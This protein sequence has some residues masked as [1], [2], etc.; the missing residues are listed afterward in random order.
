MNN[1]D[2]ASHLSDRILEDWSQRRADEGPI[3]GLI[4]LYEMIADARNL[5]VEDI[6]HD[7]RT[8]LASRAL[9][10][11]WPGFEQVAPLYTDGRVEVVVHNEE[12]PEIFAQLESDLRNQF[13]R[14]DIRIEHIGSTAVPGL[15]EKPIIDVMICVE[16][17]AAEERYVPQISS[18]GFLLYTRDDVHRFFLNPPPLPRWAQIHV[19]A[20]GGVFEREH[21]L[22]R[23]YLRDSDD[24]RNIYAR[25]KDA[26]ASKWAN[27]RNGYTYAK[28]KVIA[29]ILS[30]A[31]A[32]AVATHWSVERSLATDGIRNETR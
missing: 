15:A 20:R 10:V 24:A 32:W 23:D 3:I 6:S 22:F 21:L 5:T 2:A 27:D 12:W 19:C 13:G 1:D 7:E 11:M 28:N 31:T 29:L 14:R 16:D 18:L 4:E 30:R 9:A 26:A 25:E 8:A 17:L